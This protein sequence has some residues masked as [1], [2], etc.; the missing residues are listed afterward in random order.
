MLDDDD[1]VREATR[2]LLDGWGYDVRAFCAWQEVANAVA[3][4]SRAPDLIITDQRLPGRR[5]GIELVQ[6]LRDEFNSDI[7]ALVITG[8]VVAPTDRDLLPPRLIVLH[9]PAVALDIRNAISELR[10]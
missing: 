5:N 4:W 8:D 10:G 9:K 7:P 6:T 2:S 1:A 3:E